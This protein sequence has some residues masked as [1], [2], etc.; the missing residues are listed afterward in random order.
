MSPQVYSEIRMSVTAFEWC[1][2]WP[3]YQKYQ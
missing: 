2:K 3:F 1:K